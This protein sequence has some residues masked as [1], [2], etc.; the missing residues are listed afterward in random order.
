[1][2]A[3]VMNG[4]ELTFFSP[5]LFWIDSVLANIRLQYF[6]TILQSEISLGKSQP[7]ALEM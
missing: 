7:T 6:M 3:T 2:M 4:N 1:M 5:N